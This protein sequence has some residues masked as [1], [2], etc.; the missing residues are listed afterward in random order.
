MRRRPKKV[1]RNHKILWEITAEDFQCSLEPLF[2]SFFF[3]G[4]H[5]PFLLLLKFEPR[6]CRFDGK[7]IA[8]S[9]HFSNNRKEYCLKIKLDGVA[10][11]IQYSQAPTHKHKVQWI[12]RRLQHFR[13]DTLKGIFLSQNDVIKERFSSSSLCCYAAML[14]RR[15]KN[16]P[17]SDFA[18]R[19]P[20]TMALHELQ[21]RYSA[22]FLITQTEGEKISSSWEKFVKCAGFPPSSASSHH[23]PTYIL[24]LQWVNVNW[25]SKK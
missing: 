4:E 19:P 9:R 14:F 13:K 25:M 1:T 23:R 16:F 10:K 7:S 17:C 20:H 21:L 12:L 5:S 11:K 6:R 8:V 2:S 22:K 18:F 15:K 3:N 24:S